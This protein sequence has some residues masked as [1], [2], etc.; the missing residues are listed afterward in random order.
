[1][2]FFAILGDIKPF[3]TLGRFGAM[4]FICFAIIFVPQQSNELIERMNRVSFYARRHF[5]PRGMLV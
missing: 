3:S 4:F 2:G 5:K 1:V